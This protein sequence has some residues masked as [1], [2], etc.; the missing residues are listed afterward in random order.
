MPHPK[1]ALPPDAIADF[2]QRWQIQELALFGSVLR[3]DFRPDSDLDVLVTFAPEAHWTLFDL[4]Q[5]QD[6]LQAIV[7]RKVDIISR[8]GL[9][10]SRNHIRRQAILDSAEVVHVTG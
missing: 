9:E 8:R 1:L 5:M 7:G 2:C 6:E 3:E 4:V 10:A